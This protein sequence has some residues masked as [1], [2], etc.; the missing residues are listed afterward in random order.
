MD[1]K[2]ALYPL[3]AE[4]TIHKFS[5]NPN[6]QTSKNLVYEQIATGIRVP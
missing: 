4:G 1:T 3:D 5:C 2:E 6:R